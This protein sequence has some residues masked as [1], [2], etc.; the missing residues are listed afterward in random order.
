MVVLGVVVL[1][2]TGGEA[3]YADMGHF[4]RSSDQPVPE[5]ASFS[6]SRFGAIAVM[7]SWFVS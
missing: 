7:Q 2:I 6:A 3:K 5:G 4:S 1:A